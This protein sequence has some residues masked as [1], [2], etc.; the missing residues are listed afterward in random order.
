MKT[1]TFAGLF[2]GAACVLCNLDAAAQY[3]HHNR[4][5]YGYHRDYRQNYGY[6]YHR[7]Y[8]GYAYPRYYSPRPSISVVADLPFGAVIVRIGSTPY[9]YYRGMFYRPYGPRFII[10]TP[11]IGIIVPALPPDCT[12]VIIGGRNC[13]YYSGTYYQPLASKQGYQVI[14]GQTKP[15]DTDNSAPDL[16]YEKIV[17]DGKTYYKRGD[18]Y[19]KAIVSDSGEVTYEAVG[20]TGK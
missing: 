6:A 20:E 8:S 15:E 12:P 17:I 16:N 2:L 11:P 10:T 4:D 7:P 18:T 3:R 9:H 14:E 1:T 19:Y 5:G 13:Y